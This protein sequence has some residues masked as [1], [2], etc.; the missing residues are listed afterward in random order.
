MRVA[1]SPDEEMRELFDDLELGARY[2]AE[3][4]NGRISV[5]GMPSLRHCLILTWLV[6]QL[7]HL[8]EPRDWTGLGAGGLV[9]LPSGDRVRPD[10]S[11]V[12]GTEDLAA[13]I[14][15][16]DVLLVA[17]IITDDAHHDSAAA[18]REGCSR[19]GI[20][21]YLLIDTLAGPTTVTLYSAPLF[22]SYRSITQVPAGDKLHL[23]LPFDTVLDTAA[24]LDTTTLPLV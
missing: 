5:R 21:F 13:G 10:L 3:L 17:E 19:A 9:L 6:Y 11:V 12:R 24:L 8:G 2:R 14:R 16:E 22:D 23:P 18:V 7:R 15:A 20:P 4:I 1:P